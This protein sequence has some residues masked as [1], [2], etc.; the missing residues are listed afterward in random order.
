MA[1]NSARC[2]GHSSGVHKYQRFKIGRK[3]DY[4]IY[5]CMHTGCAHY[6][7][8]NLLVGRS[9]ICWMC[10][11]EFQIV[12]GKQIPKPLCPKCRKKYNLKFTPIQKEIT[13]NGI[14]DSQIQMGSHSGTQQTTKETTY[15]WDSIGQSGNTG[16]ESVPQIKELDENASSALLESLFQDILQK[17]SK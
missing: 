8:Q 1:S 3:K 12:K 5:K 15:G 10:D 11:Q 7:E 13:L 17:S 16:K 6:I 14:E 4:I 2:R 9:S